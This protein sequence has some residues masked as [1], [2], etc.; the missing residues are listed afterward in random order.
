M[1]NRTLISTNAIFGRNGTRY[2]TTYFHV[3]TMIILSHR[4]S[5]SPFIQPNS[6]Y[7]KMQN[8]N[9]CNNWTYYYE[10]V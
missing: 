9:T 10:K 4:T 8:A 3:I 6:L 7:I 2:G 5:R 1:K